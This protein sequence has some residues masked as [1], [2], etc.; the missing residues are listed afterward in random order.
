MWEGFHRLKSPALLLRIHM[1]ERTRWGKSLGPPQICDLVLIPTLFWPAHEVF[2][3]VVLFGMKPFKLIFSTGCLFLLHVFKSYLEVPRLIWVTISFK[4]TK[5]IKKK[6][7]YS[8]IIT[9]SPLI[10]NSKFQVFMTSVLCHKVSFGVFFFC[11]VFP[12]GQKIN[13]HP[14]Q[15]SLT[16]LFSRWWLFCPSNKMKIQW[17]GQ[18]FTL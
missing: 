2:P 6:W 11:F 9:T 14:A 4:A 7:N 5:S 10:F 17:T 8:S 1:T 3:P 13:L 15:R 18:K 16:Y 12:S